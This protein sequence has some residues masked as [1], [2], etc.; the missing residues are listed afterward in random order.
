MENQLLKK[1]GIEKVKI[2]DNNFDEIYG[3]YEKKAKELGFYGE[4]KIIKEHGKIIIYV[5]I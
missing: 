5:V 4:L 3:R 2:F 1:L